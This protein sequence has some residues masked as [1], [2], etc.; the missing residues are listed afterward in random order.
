MKSEVFFSAVEFIGLSARRSTGDDGGGGHPSEDDEQREPLDQATERWRNTGIEETGRGD[1]NEHY[2]REHD[3][4]RPG[5]AA[6]GR[7]WNETGNSRQDSVNG[8]LGEK[9][10]NRVFPA[11]CRTVPEGVIPRQPCDR[12][13][14]AKHDKSLQHTPA[15][16]A[17]PQRTEQPDPERTLHRTRPVRRIQGWAWPGA[18]S[19][20]K[21]LNHKIAGLEV[22]RA[23]RSALGT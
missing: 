8:H 16:D 6:A 14:D 5:R 17:A 13:G 20:L 11:H 7:R 21:L 9:V 18:A 3:D 19:R 22:S 15:E 2:G 1:Q 12:S 4:G 10:V 23:L